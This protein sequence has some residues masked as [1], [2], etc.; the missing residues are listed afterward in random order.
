[1]NFTLICVTLFS[2][3]QNDIEINN[4]E[5]FDITEI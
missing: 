4:Q 5:A 1:M 3:Y 2:C